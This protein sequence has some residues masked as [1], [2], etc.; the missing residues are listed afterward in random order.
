MKPSNNFGELL[1]AC[2]SGSGYVDTDNDGVKELGE[3]AISGVRAV[4][5]HEQSRGRRQYDDDDEREWLC[6]QFTGL[7][8]AHTR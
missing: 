8:P 5:R 4:D 7:R 6:N 2:I 1:P 3:A